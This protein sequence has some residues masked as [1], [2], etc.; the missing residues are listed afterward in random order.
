MYIFIVVCI[1]TPYPTEAMS[2][3]RVACEGINRDI[4][5]GRVVETLSSQDIEPKIL[6]CW[7]FL[8]YTN[9]HKIKS[10]YMTHSPS[11]NLPRA[12]AIGRTD[13]FGI[14]HVTGMV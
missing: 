10:D 5:C 13:F 3:I 14:W 6:F 4:G 9:D 2:R 1:R 11:R 12:T 7:A 8:L